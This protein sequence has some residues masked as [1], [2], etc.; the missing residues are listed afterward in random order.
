[1]IDSLYERLGG[2][3]AI[4]KAVDIFYEKVLADLRINHF[5]KDLDMKRQSA[6]QKSFLTF[7]FGGSTKYDGKTMRAAHA[8]PVEKG[9]N[10][11]HFDA[12]MEH[13]ASTLEELS[14]PPEVI[15]EAANIAESVR[16]DVLGR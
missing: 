1:M 8:S 13:L 7:A 16:N 9:L 3:A 5:F 6:M 4:D 12:V 2:A 14:V 15:K 10:D 11:S